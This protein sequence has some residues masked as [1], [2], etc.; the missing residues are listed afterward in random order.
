[1]GDFLFMKSSLWVGYKGMAE[2]GCGEE[3]D[4]GLVCWVPREDMLEDEATRLG[5][6]G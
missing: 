2:G 5:E 3:K 6:V 1:M 4:W